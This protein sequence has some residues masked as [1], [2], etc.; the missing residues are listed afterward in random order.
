MLKS[1][2]IE[3]S[4]QE[5]DRDLKNVNNYKHTNNAYTL[6]IRK[7][8]AKEESEY[9]FGTRNTNKKIT[10]KSNNS[11]HDEDDEEKYSEQIY[12]DNNENESHRNLELDLAPTTTNREHYYYNNNHLQTKRLLEEIQGKDNNYFK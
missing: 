8:D 12:R 7:L 3:F 5:K 1:N 11:V 2:N 4:S 10:F 9:D 6:K